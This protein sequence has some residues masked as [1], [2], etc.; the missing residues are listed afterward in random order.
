M[1]WVQ[2]SPNDYLYAIETGVVLG[3][4]GL[5]YSSEINF[6]RRPI[7]RAAEYMVVS[8]LASGGS[9]D[10]LGANATFDL[11]GAWAESAAAASRVK[12]IDDI[13][14]TG[15][16][17]TETDGQVQIRKYPMPYYYIG[18]TTGGD[19]SDQTMTIKITI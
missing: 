3:S 17:S 4:T 2:S 1:A 19:D 11:Y 15:K 9:G 5:T 12:L 8:F 6:L 7:I 16:A 18:I 13:I 14:A 10:P